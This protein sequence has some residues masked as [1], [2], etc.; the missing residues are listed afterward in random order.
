M[1]HLAVITIALG[2]LAGPVYAET[3]PQPAD[4][5]TGVNTETK[6]PKPEPSTGTSTSTDTKTK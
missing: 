6:T 2:L 3:G 1:K 4:K 5:T